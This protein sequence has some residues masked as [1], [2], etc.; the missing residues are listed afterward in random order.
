MY[1]IGTANQL[2]VDTLYRL[3]DKIEKASGW[4]KFNNLTIVLGV[5]MDVYYN[6]WTIVEIISHT[7]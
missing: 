4:F 7:Y 2:S 5:K 3:N 1:R 6:L